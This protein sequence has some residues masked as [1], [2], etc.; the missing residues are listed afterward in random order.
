MLFSPAAEDRQKTGAGVI[1]CLVKPK[2]D[3]T[4]VIAMENHNHHP[5]NLEEGQL[6]GALE[7]VNVPPTVHAVNSAK[8]PIYTKD[9]TNK[10]LW[11]LDIE[12]KFGGESQEIPMCN[13]G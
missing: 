10:V 6:L 8:P 2:P 13:C 4:M 3:C 7:P 11:Q 5:V 9:W 1:P 12:D